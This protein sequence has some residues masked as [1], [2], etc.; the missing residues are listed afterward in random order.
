MQQTRRT[1]S[2]VVI[3]NSIALQRSGLIIS[4]PISF[5]RWEQAGH[6]LISFAE[7]TAWWIADWLAYGESSFHDRYREAVER[8][9][10]SYQTLRNY[11]W[12]AR[13]FDL[14]RR[15]DNLS[16]GHHAEVAAL[17]RPEQDYWLRKA[18]EFGWSR[19]QLRSNVKASLKERNVDKDTDSP[20]V[21]VTAGT[22]VQSELAGP[23][24]IA[25]ICDNLILCLTPGQ[26]AQFAAVANA[27]QLR[28]DEW[29]IQVLEL[30]AST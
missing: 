24:R 3:D 7:S 25:Q 21:T 1:P 11:V 23:G 20:Q 12:I 26:I 22:S 15:R 2:P 29:A 5:H 28:V 10:L 6:Q 18:E 9:S 8:T 16:F 19:N 4:G 13:R 27:Q 17:D 14:S 30:A